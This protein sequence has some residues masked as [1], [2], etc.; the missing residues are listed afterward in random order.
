LKR[1]SLTIDD[2]TLNL[3][4]EWVEEYDLE[5]KG[6]R[7]GYIVSLIKRYTPTPPN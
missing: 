7:S 1:I 3:V 5:N 4:N 6:N 2:V